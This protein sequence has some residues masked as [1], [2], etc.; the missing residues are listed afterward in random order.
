[1]EYH[2]TQLDAHGAKFIC[3]CVCVCT[4]LP[5]CVGSVSVRVSKKLQCM[6]MSVCVCL[7][8]SVKV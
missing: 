2:F 5:D 8:E 6:F 4:S 3:V 7:F 1:M